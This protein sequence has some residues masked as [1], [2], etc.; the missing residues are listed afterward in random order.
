MGSS[1]QA[2]HADFL[3]RGLS[4]FSP[5]ALG[6]GLLPLREMKLFARLLTAAESSEKQ[7]LFF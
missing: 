5:R 4:L 2:V 7:S 3:H 1:S 6:A